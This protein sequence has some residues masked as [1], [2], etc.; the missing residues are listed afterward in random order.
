LLRKTYNIIVNYYLIKKTMAITEAEARQ[1]DTC[2][3]CKTP[4]EKG[5]IMCWECWRTFKNT[6][7]TI[8]SWILSHNL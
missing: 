3:K 6:D 1:L 7:T 2:P 4:K 8:E 5:M